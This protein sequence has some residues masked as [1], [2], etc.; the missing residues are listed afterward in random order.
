MLV[1]NHPE[2]KQVEKKKKPLRESKGG[3]LSDEIFTSLKE[4]AIKGVEDEYAPDK[5]K[6]KPDFI[7]DI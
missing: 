7:V 4:Y 1:V 5:K 6:E 2:P 3:V